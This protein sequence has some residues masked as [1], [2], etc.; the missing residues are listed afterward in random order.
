MVSNNGK[1]VREHKLVMEKHIGRKLKPNE[2]VH[3]KNENR[4][5]NRIENLQLMTVSEHQTYH[6]LGKHH[7]NEAKAKISTFNLGK[8]LSLETRLKMSESK[9]GAKNPFFGKHHTQETIDRILAT[10]QLTRHL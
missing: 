3:H 10:K 6:R 7:S 5:D 1:D 8:K 9:K 4:L 2:C